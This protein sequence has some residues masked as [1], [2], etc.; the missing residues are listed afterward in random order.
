MQ[1]DANIQILLFGKFFQSS[2]YAVQKLSHA[3]ETKRDKQSFLF[4]SRPN[5]K[6][7]NLINVKRTAM[8]H[9]EV[10]AYPRA[11]LLETISSKV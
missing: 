7:E 1:M 6:G 9:K 11:G 3:D 5:I 2:L 10:K 8:A 4:H